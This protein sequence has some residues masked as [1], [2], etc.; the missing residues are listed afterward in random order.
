MNDAY[1]FALANATLCAVIMFIALCRLNA[2][3]GNVLVRVQ[4]EYAA[5][6]S[7]ALASAFQPYWGEWPRWGSIAMAVG[8]LIGL[9][10]SSHA[11]RRDTPPSSATQPA[12]L[13]DQ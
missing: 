9:I 6:L 7:C 10:C 12:N 1:L 5:Y 2:M 11:W 3:Q 4:S 8:M 13:E